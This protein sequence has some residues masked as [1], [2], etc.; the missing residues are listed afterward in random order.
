MK[1]TV[2]TFL[3]L[4]GVMQGA[5][6]P[7]ED[8]SGGFDRGGWLVPLADEDMRQIVDGWFTQAD[9]ILLGRSTYEAMQA[10]WPDVTDP[11]NF[12][13]TSLNGLPKHVVSTTLTDPGWAN[14]SAH[15]ARRG[16]R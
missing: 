9:E 8:T 14:T 11:E 6:A 1:L 3:S 7:D 16:P 10:Y 12:V 2:H 4:D 13:A 15:A 5:G